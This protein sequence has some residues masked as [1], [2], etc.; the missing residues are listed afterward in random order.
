MPKRGITVKI[1]ERRRHNSE[2]PFEV[3]WKEK[4]KQKHAGYHPP[5]ESAEQMRKVCQELLDRVG[6]TKVIRVERVRQGLVI[7]DFERLCANFLQY[8]ARIRTSFYTQLFYS[9]KLKWLCERIDR[10]DDQ[11]ASR[12]RV[13]NLLLNCGNGYEFQRGILRALSAVMNWG[14]QQIPPI[15]PPSFTKRIRLEKPRNQ[16]P[17]N[18]FTVE[19]VLAMMNHVKGK[20]VQLAFALKFFA[21]IRT[22]EI[23]RMRTELINPEERSIYI[24]RN[25][26]KTTGLME[27]LPEAFW[28]WYPKDPPTP[29]VCPVKPEQLIRKIVRYLD[30]CPRQMLKSTS[31]RTFASYAATEYGLER[32]RRGMRHDMG[33]QTMEKHYLCCAT[34]RYGKPYLATA[35]RCKA[36]FSI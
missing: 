33:M 29:M 20:R 32:T 15:S 14:N 25:V 22:A 2:N 3:Y 30:L 24:P 23:S 7:E 12:A 10:L 31:R 34:E 35:E 17:P 26:G 36:Y 5:L 8:Q 4:G 11:E 18:F 16:P 28:R 19:E 21:G 27:N 13:S 9:E 6:E 1:R